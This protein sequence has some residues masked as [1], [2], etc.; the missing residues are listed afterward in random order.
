[1]KCVDLF[2]LN[3]PPKW[4]YIYQMMDIARPQQTASCY[5]LWWYQSSPSPPAWRRWTTTTTTS[6]SS[7][8]DVGAQQPWQRRPHSARRGRGTDRRRT[9][10]QH[11]RCCC[12]RLLL[13]CLS[14]LASTWAIKSFIFSNI[15]SNKLI[16]KTFSL[17]N[18]KIHVIKISR[19]FFSFYRK[20]YLIINLF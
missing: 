11:R 16:K 8:G 19:C 7:G 9:P 10:S 3:P 17:T 18:T 15:D 4:G 1:M 6:S 12:H 13:C 20:I 14:F 2:G 5:E